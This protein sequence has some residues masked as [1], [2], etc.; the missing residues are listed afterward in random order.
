MK[1][2]L[3]ETYVHM[4][5]R[6]FDL[7]SPASCTPE[8][9]AAFCAPPGQ[10]LR[11]GHAA[12]TT[13]APPH[14]QQLRHLRRART[15]AAAAAC[16][17]S[18]AAAPARIYEA[19]AL[20]NTIDWRDLRATPA[21]RPTTRSS[22]ASDPGGHRGRLR[23]RRPA[24]LRGQQQLQLRHRQQR[25]RP[26]RRHLHPDHLRRHQRRRARFYLSVNGGS[27]ISVQHERPR[28]GSPRWR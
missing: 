15:P 18:A 28:T 23:R 5:E 25:Q 7:P 16:P 21:P 22:A 8:S 2:V 1:T 4:W 3:S 6:N 9:N 14:R 12:P 13:A 19:E 27:T 20:G 24:A 17:T 11:R 10:E 26:H